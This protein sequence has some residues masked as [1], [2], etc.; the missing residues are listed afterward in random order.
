VPRG[1]GLR[2]THKQSR[3]QA[4][5]HIL[6][7]QQQQQQQ[8]VGCLL[9]CQHGPCVMGAGLLAALPGLGAVLG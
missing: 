6:P 2:S 9:C 5:E 4:Q 1:E 8:Q 7:Q 3:H